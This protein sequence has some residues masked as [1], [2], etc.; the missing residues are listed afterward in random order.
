MNL[1]VIA[2]TLA[3]LLLVQTAFAAG[4]LNPGLYQ[5]HDHGFGTQGPDYGLRVD[6]LGKIFSTDLGGASVT[7]FWDGGATATLSGLLHDNATTDLWTV[8]YTIT[9]I[10]AVGTEGFTATGGSGTLTDPLLNVTVLTAEQNN[11][12]SAFDFLADGHRIPGD[13]T[14][15]V[16]R[17]WLL[18]PNSVDDWLI[19][20]ELIPEPATLALVSLGGLMIARRR[21]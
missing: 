13:S 20:G 17:G 14:T 10:T 6:G 5:I 4:T 7:M 2:P 19:R 18:P 15:A 8:N 1:R 21:H 12:G 11:S 3:L 16:G 9:G